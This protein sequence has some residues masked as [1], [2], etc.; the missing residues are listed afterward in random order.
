MRFRRLF[1]PLAAAAVLSLAYGAMMTSAQGVLLYPFS[2]RDLPVPGWERLEI[3]VPGDSPVPA[4]V[5]REGSGPWV[6][7][8]MGNG[9][10]VGLFASW[11]E[12]HEAAGRPVA[13]LAYRGGG[14]VPGTPSE[15]RL[16]ADALAL[17]DWAMAE[18]G[19]P[20]ILHGFSLGSG[21]A[22]EVAARREV[23]A[24]VLEAP[25]AR[26]CDLMRRATWL[27]A[28]RMPV[29]RWDNL[30]LAAGVRAPVLILHGEAD[31]VIPVAESERLAAALAAAGVA[32]EFDRVP[33]GRHGNLPR[34]PFYAPRISDFLAGAVARQAGGAPEPPLSPG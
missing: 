22:L 12:V 31:E 30:A 13:A 24:V 8:F 15:A 18:S 17:A 2:E 34:L 4:Y 28:C 25:F 3:A 1:R 5:R 11:L 26:A 6:L 33:A 21:L 19:G 23:V 29:D 10:A 32:A 27:P 7:F 16:K 20:V 14:G 9:G